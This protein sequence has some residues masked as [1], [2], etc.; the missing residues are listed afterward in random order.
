MTIC[1]QWHSIGCHCKQEKSEISEV[2]ILKVENLTYW[3]TAQAQAKQPREASA[4]VSTSTSCPGRRADQGCQRRTGYRSWG[5]AELYVL[6]QYW[7]WIWMKH[8]LTLLSLEPGGRGRVHP[9]KLHMGRTTG[10]CKIEK[11]SHKMGFSSPRP[12]KFLVCTFLRHPW[13]V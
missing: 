12:V 2:D 5:R 3:Q 11:I 13:V 4:V 7:S 10:A 9:D 1:R 8:W 6:W